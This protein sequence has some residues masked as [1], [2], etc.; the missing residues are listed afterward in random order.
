MSQS[1]SSSKL[2]FTAG[3]IE[4]QLLKSFEVDSP[5]L[6]PQE[7]QR[8]RTA[9]TNFRSL[10]HRKC[11]LTG[12]SIISMYR[13]NAPFP[14]YDSEAW[15][16]DRWSAQDY[17]LEYDPTRPFLLQWNE[18]FHKT[19]SYLTDKD[20]NDEL[21]YIKY[22]R[23]QAISGLN[24]E[25]QDKYYENAETVS[26][27][28][29]FIMKTQLIKRLESSFYAFKNSLGNFQTASDRMIKML[30]SYHVN[31]KVFIAPDSN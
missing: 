14:V 12:A 7:R 29:A 3:P 10:Y 17:A 5:R 19:V 4:Q 27:S 18:L 20:S 23:Y 2:S 8:R 11:D 15:W 6:S 16:T 26:K 22:K 25:V 13:D 21:I 30:E 24:K 28:L 31:G 9:F 1:C